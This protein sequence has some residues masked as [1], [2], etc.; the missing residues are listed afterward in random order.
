MTIKNLYPDTRPQT[1]YNVINGRPELPA[2]S[3]FSRATVGTYVDSAG[4]VVFAQVNEARFD[5]IEQGLLLEAAV[6]NSSRDSNNW[7]NRSG[8]GYGIKPTITN[9]AGISPDRANNATL[10]TTKDTDE[11]NRLLTSIDVPSAGYKVC[12]SIHVK[13]GN[14]PEVTFLIGGGSVFNGFVRFNFDTETITSNDN[15]TNWQDNGGFYKLANGWYR[16]WG[17]AQSWTSGNA[18]I[19][20]SGGRAAGKTWYQYGEQIEVGYREPTFRPS[21]YF[22]TSGGRATRAADVFSLTT[23]N[24]LN[25]GFSLLLDS[26][27]ATRDFLYKI[28]A[29]GSTIASLSNDNGT[30]DWNV[31]G[32][33][34]ANSTP[35]LYPQ[36][37][38][39]FGRIR[40]VS[41]FGSADGSVQNNYLY[42]TGISFPTPAEVAS[43]ADELEFGVPQTLKALYVWNGQLSDTEAVSVIKGEYN[44]VPIDTDDIDNPDPV[45]NPYYSYVYNSDPKNDGNTYITLPF[46]VPTESMRIYWGD[47][48]Q[49]KRYE[50]GVIPDH[51]YPYPGQYRIKI[52]A[53][54]GLDKAR[55]SNV[56]NTI[57]RVDNWAPQHRVN[58][59]GP[60]F[61]GTQL[62]NFLENQYYNTQ[63][64]RFKYTNLTELK[65]TFYS[66]SAEAANNWDWVPVNLPVCT[67][68]DATFQEGFTK[69]TDA[70]KTTFPQLQT[71]S[72]LKD[73]SNCFRGTTL[74]SFP[75]NGLPFS[76]TSNVE[77]WIG[78]FA[79][80]LGLTT[81]GNLDTSS[82]ISLR[83]I[84]R[85]CNK[86]TNLPSLDYSNVTSLYY[87]FEQTKISSFAANQTSKVTDI[88]SAW[89]NCSELTS[90]PSID[91]S[92]VIYCQY[93]WKSTTKLVNFPALDFSSVTDKFDRTWSACGLTSF[94]ADTILPVGEI[95]FNSSFY[96]APN[97]TTMPNYPAS[98]TQR[99]NNIGAAWRGCGKL[100]S[101]PEWDLRNCTGFGQ[102]FYGC[103]ID[104]AG[105]PKTFNTSKGNNFAYSWLSNKMT[106]FPYAGWTPADGSYGFQSATSF[107]QAWWGCSQ[108]TD[109]A[110]NL[111]DTTGDLAEDAFASAWGRS[112]KLSAQSI[113][114]IILSCVTNGQSDVKLDVSSD[115]TFGGQNAK[116][117]DWSQAAKDGAATLESRGW[118]IIYRS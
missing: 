14:T 12:Y 13:R 89:S 10:I 26:D 85:G 92:K 31:N 118:T 46:I 117:S 116:Y 94:P 110:A 77:K 6:E 72:A 102:V 114:N 99:I 93:A 8:A 82:A 17:Q 33:S 2:A 76:D 22:E 42:T 87:A 115:P 71:S 83:E 28:K 108:L 73:V 15:G 67:T 53:D 24:D 50:Q 84:L 61:S 59:P 60:G 9:N 18:S 97:L 47:G 44:V 112:C 69:C 49:D 36:V 32:T 7:Q 109:V 40:T 103:S 51:T 80:C 62:N 63:I 25:S 19:G 66:S 27:S 48:D 111:F 68:L 30:L 41:S 107:L 21:S 96:G 64:P 38:F 98:V 113:E 81:F 100:T 4:Y 58:D 75:T 70:E 35:P 16:I 52:K 37:G 90:F 56:P 39:V 23:K 5:A 11:D 88:R 105:M 74:K 3:T 43:G 101:F 55:P 86:F 104:D 1:V 54:D 91:T 78:T 79:Y 57:Y 95:N 65:S 34:A 106:T 20:S 45:I 29:N